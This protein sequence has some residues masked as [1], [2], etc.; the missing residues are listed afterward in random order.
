MVRENHHKIELLSLSFGPIRE[1]QLLWYLQLT[2][3]KCQWFLLLIFVIVT[4]DFSQIN[5]IYYIYSVINL[6]NVS[7]LTLNA[8]V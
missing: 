6:P 3:R 7:L 5:F 4:V 8:I 1:L 2:K